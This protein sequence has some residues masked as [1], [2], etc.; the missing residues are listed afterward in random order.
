[1]LL[2]RALPIRIISAICTRLVGSRSKILPACAYRT[3]GF[4]T[5][6]GLPVNGQ[7]ILR[8]NRRLPFRQT[9]VV[10]DH[11]RGNLGQQK[12]DWPRRREAE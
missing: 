6:S 5:A 8:G 4:D 9:N 7:S 11:K 3:V 1:M 12:Q 10:G 2:A